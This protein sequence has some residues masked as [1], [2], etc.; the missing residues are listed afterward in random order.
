M[1]TESSTVELRAAFTRLQGLLLDTPAAAA[2]VAQLAEVIRDLIPLA[3]GAG[4]TLIDKYGEPTSLAATDPQ[5]EAVD[6]MQYELGQGPCLAAW[7]TVTFQ[8]VE[9]TLTE[10]RWPDWAAAAAA[11]GVRS[12]LSTPLL[13]RGQEIG[14]VKIYAAEPEAFT[15]YEEHLLELLA[16]AAATL[17]G[18]IRDSRTAHQLTTDLEDT[19]ADRLVIQQAVGLLMGRYDLDTDTAHDRLLRTARQQQ[20]PVLEVAQA[21]LHPTEDPAAEEP[22][23][24][25]ARGR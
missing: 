24:R 15:D 5:V 21:L 1:A 4:V 23:K 11:T 17:L 22:S 12:V 2:S 19:L 9:D 8:R 10:T 18:A 25:R 3:V 14:A 20:I 16:G 13:Y 6:R 7:D